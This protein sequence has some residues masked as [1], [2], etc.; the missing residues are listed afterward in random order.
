MKRVNEN[1]KSFVCEREMKSLETLNQVI[2]K[3]SILETLNHIFL[4]LFLSLMWFKSI[5]IFF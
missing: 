3:N 5:S 4:N 2:I 1:A